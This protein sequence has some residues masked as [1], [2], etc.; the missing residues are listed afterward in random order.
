MVGDLTNS[1][2]DG[3]VIGLGAILDQ[4][5]FLR[6]ETLLLTVLRWCLIKKAKYFQVIGLC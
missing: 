4:L 1:T 2:S 5:E 3:K 6:Q